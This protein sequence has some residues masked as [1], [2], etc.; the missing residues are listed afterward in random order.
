LGYSALVKFENNRMYLQNGPGQ[1]PFTLN[2]KNLEQYWTG[3]VYLPWK[4]FSDYTGVAPITS[5]VETIL[6]LKKHLKASGFDK[7]PDNSNYDAFTRRAIQTI[8]KKNGLKPDGLVGPM[9]KIILYNQSESWKIP[10]LI[11]N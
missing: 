4:N 11:G 10:H 7:I 9:T 3:M 2:E 1:E 5:P 6:A 8:Q